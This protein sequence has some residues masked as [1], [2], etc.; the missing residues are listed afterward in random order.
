ME[1]TREILTQNQKHDSRVLQL[2]SMVTGEHSTEQSIVDASPV[3]P[4]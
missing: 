1:M 2:A 4:D 3:S